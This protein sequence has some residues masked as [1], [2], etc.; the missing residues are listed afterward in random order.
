MRYI[1]LLIAIV[2]FT[3]AL[4]LTGASCLDVPDYLHLQTALKSAQSQKNG[5]FGNNMWGVVVNRDG[6]VCAVA[7]SG[8]SRMDQWQ[9]SRIIAAKKANAASA[10]ST[11]CYSF[12]T[13]NLFWPSQPH[14]SLWGLNEA[15]PTNIHATFEGDPEQF[16]TSLDPMVGTVVGGVIPFGGGLP[17][18]NSI[19][20]LVGGLGV[21]GDTSCTDHNVAWRVRHELDLDYVPGG[22]N[23]DL[24]RKD[25][26]IFDISP[27]RHGVK[28]S[29]TGFGHPFCIVG[30][31]QNEKTIANALPAARKKKTEL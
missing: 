26:I 10:F 31:E 2:A 20:E 5:G 7:F 27:N 28:H 17:L 24:A 29:R 23:S 9:G 6:I 12:S 16:G 4:K 22:S 1:L 13:A 3:K 15:V 11:T 25:N 14:E 30:E 19:G 8:N 18:Y 21:S